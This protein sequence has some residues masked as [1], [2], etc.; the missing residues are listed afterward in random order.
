L[1]LQQRAALAS[2]ALFQQG[3][4]DIQDEASQ[5]LAGLAGVKRGQV[6]VDFCAGAGGKTLAMGALMRNS[7]QIF[8]MDISASRLQAMAPRVSRAGLTN[9][10]TWVLQSEH[11]ERLK[12]LR[13][14]ADV[15][16]VDAPCSGLGTLRRSPELKW[17]V[18]PEALQAMAE[19]Q[20][21]ILNSAAEL[22]KPG[23][24][25][26]YATCSFM[27]EEDEGVALAFDASHSGFEPVAAQPVLD[28]LVGHA[29]H[30]LCDA[31][32]R[33]M[34]AWP[35]RHQTDGFFASI[36]RAR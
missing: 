8:A 33:W 36:W 6:V 31:T 27:R 18:T 11:D 3:A 4:V 25:L 17:R 20:S 5:L 32:G 24:R 2:S 19:L 13:G 15:V 35:H 16:L 34:R 12:R 30:G 14:K 7:G 9:V 29:D 10:S 23:G 1:R 28:A 22:V 21:R 26:V